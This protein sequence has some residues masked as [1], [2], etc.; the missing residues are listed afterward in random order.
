[1]PE[2]LLDA[3]DAPLEVWPG[4]VGGGEKFV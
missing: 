3:T 4:L 1:L 2:E